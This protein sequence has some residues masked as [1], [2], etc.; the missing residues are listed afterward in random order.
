MNRKQAGK[1]NYHGQFHIIC[2]CG[3][4][5]FMTNK[6]VHSSTVNL[7]EISVNRCIKFEN[8][9]KKLCFLQKHKNVQYDLQE[10]SQRN[11][12]TITSVGF[13]MQQILLAFG[14]GSLRFHESSR[15]AK[16]QSMELF[17]PRSL[18]CTILTSVVIS[19]CNRSCKQKC[20]WKHYSICSFA[21]FNFLHSTQKLMVTYDVRS[22]VSSSHFRLDLS[23]SSSLCIIIRVD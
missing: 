23:V 13:S 9:D 2:S 11:K 22:S 17:V 15:C 6:P 19:Q 16:V 20:C 14:D 1:R 21:T 4:N 5:L 10:H 18:L 8:A 7:F 3:T 12:S